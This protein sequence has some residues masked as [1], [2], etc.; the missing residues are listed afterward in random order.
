VAAAVGGGP[1]PTAGELASVSGGL[2]LVPVD[3]TLDRGASLVAESA[4]GHVVVVDGDGVPVGVL[5]TL[6]VVGAL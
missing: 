4:L 3:A 6:D 2:A 1:R 5:S